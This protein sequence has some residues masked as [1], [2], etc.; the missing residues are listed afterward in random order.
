MKPINTPGWI[1]EASHPL[2]GK[3]NTSI[4]INDKVVRPFEV[5]SVEPC[6]HGRQLFVASFR[7]ILRGDLYANKCQ[8]SDTLL[9]GTYM[10]VD[11]VPTA[12]TYYQII[13]LPTYTYLYTHYLNIYSETMI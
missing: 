7:L 13:Q 5:L 4:S 12:S 9:G 1:L 8:D 2:V 3:D 11:S 10:L 6:Y